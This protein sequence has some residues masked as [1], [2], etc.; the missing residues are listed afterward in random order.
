[1]DYTREYHQDWN[2]TANGTISTVTAIGGTLGDLFAVSVPIS[3]MFTLIDLTQ[4]DQSLV[5]YILAPIYINIF[6]FGIFG[7]TFSRYSFVYLISLFLW[8]ISMGLETAK[9][10]YD[11]AVSLFYDE[12]DIFTVL[13]TFTGLVQIATCWFFIMVNLRLTKGYKQS[14]HRMKMK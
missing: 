1:M 7:V 5:A 12:T 14:A 2:I 4:L 10:Y 11:V 8:M 13:W 6:V 9:F 3:V